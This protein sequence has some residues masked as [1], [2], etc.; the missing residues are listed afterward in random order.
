VTVPSGHGTSIFSLVSDET[1]PDTMNPRTSHPHERRRTH[2]RRSRTQ[3][4]LILH[5]ECSTRVG[6]ALIWAAAA[7]WCVLVWTAVYLAV[8]TLVMH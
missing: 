4:R 7:L 6:P 1:T 3:S 5:G 2:L 8:G